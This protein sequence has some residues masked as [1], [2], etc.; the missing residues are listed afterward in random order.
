MSENLP[1]SPTLVSNNAA[2]ED[3]SKIAAM[4]A[5]E[6]ADDR[7]GGDILL[8]DVAEVSYLADYFVIVT[9]F[10]KAQVRAIAQSIQEKLETK[11]QRVPRQIEGQAE[12]TWVLLDYG[13]LIVHILMSQER[14]F[15]N[16]EAFSGHAET[17]K[18]P[19]AS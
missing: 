13:D 18:Y 6:A 7:K 2:K 3:E 16:L 10:S 19:L 14:E 17:I 15:Y 12:G 4:L 5:A 1:S 11:L 8:L 9:G